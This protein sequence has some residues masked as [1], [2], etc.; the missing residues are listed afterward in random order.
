M[1]CLTITK[2]VSKGLLLTA[3]LLSLSACTRPY[4]WESTPQTTTNSQVNQAS[5][6]PEQIQGATGTV[7]EQPANYREADRPPP[8]Y[9]T[10]RK[11][12]VTVGG[13]EVC[14]YDCQV[15]GDFAKCAAD[16]KQ[17][18]VIGPT[19][20][21]DCGYDCQVTHAE[22]QCG[23]YLYDNCVANDLGE[24]RCGN[25]CYKREDGELICG[26]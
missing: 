7:I 20:E 6:S 1:N 5:N 16:P 9:Q 25:N 23:Q 12:C 22:A 13:H 24:I 15:V 18:C 21:I 10:V 19:G 8:R 17:K 4:F 2:Q 11:Q 26:K 14:G 3:F